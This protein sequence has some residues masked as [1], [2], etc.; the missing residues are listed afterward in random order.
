[1]GTTLARIEENV[2]P[3]ILPRELRRKQSLTLREAIWVW[4]EFL[5]LPWIAICVLIVVHSSSVAIQVVGIAIGCI[6]VLAFVGILGDRLEKGKYYDRTKRALR[7]RS[8]LDAPHATDRKGRHK[9]VKYTLYGAHLETHRGSVEI[10]ICESGDKIQVAKLLYNAGAKR[11][12]FPAQGTATITM[13]K[14]TLEELTAAADEAE[15]LA[16]AME[17]GD[18]E[19]NLKRLKVDRMAL[20]IKRPSRRMRSELCPNCDE[21]KEIEAGDYICIDCRKKGK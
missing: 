10:S 16:K 6:S 21:E 14:P 13:V 5:I 17:Q 18:Y 12:Y 2:T 7:R 15:E 8:I 20:M 1:M 9:E 19:E 4:D 11:G 3:K